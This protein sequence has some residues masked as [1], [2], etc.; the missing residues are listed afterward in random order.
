[1]DGNWWE[2]NA[3]MMQ[4]SNIRHSLY[5][6]PAGSKLKHLISSSYVISV[7]VSATDTSD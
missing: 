7:K 5:A 3:C 6:L 2:H 4:E 1:M